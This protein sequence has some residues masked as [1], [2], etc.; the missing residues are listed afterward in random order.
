M[1]QAVIRYT[2]NRLQFVPAERG[3]NIWRAKHGLIR[4]LSRAQR[5]YIKRVREVYM[6]PS[7]APPEYR[8][9][10]AKREAEQGTQ[11]N[12]PVTQDFWWQK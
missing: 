7:V 12:L 2:N 6:A 4:R 1:A 8:E 11:I 5:A 9:A 3:A 10:R